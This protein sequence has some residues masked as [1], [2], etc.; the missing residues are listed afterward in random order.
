MLGR[1]EGIRPAGTKGRPKPQG[2]TDL[3]VLRSLAPEQRPLPDLLYPMSNSGGQSVGG[4]T[5]WSAM[6][7]GQWTIK[8]FGRRR[9][10]TIS[11]VIAV[12]HHSINM[13]SL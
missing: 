7:N 11:I 6:D 13:K 3:G 12:V 9:Q 1:Q 8:E 4:K 2:R 5:E 10:R